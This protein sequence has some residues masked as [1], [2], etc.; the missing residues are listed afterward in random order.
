M[1]NGIRDYTVQNILLVHNFI[2]IFLIF[3][4]SF[5]TF[6]IIFV[7]KWFNYKTFIDIGLPTLYFDG[8]KEFWTIL[9]KRISVFKFFGHNIILEIIWTIIPILIIL[10]LIFPSLSLIGEDTLFTGSSDTLIYPVS[11]VG[12]QWFWEYDLFN[13]DNIIKTLIKSYINL[14]SNIRLLG[15]DNALIL[16]LGINI[17]LCITSEDVAHSF[18]IPALGLKLDAIP[19][20]I[21]A[22]RIRLTRLGMYSGM[23]S[24]LC[25]IEHGFMPISLQSV[26]F[27]E[28]VAQNINFINSININYNLMIETLK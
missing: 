5:V 11:I 23:C 20:R 26:L 17:I 19:G 28:F 8:F 4:L 7:I 25:G 3:V 1:L 16:P 2:L 9:N 27:T 14:R 10:C 18:A 24:E 22:K 12:N 13:L 6:Y 15:T 21:N